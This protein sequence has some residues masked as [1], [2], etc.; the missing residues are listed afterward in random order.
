MRHTLYVKIDEV[1]LSEFVSEAGSIPSTIKDLNSY[2]SKAKSI[3]DKVRSIEAK[4]QIMEMITSAEAQRRSI[5]EQ[6]LSDK[7]QDLME[8]MERRARS[9]AESEHSTYDVSTCVARGSNPEVVGYSSTFERLYEVHMVGAFLGYD[10]RDM[11]ILVYG[12]IKGDLKVG[13]SM[14]V[15]GSRVVS[16]VKN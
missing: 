4:G 3:Q 8:M 16:D 2:V 10:K 14:S 6:E 15:T 9:T 7:M 5:L 1:Y 12:K 13:V 11:E